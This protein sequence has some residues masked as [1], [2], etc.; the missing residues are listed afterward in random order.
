MNVFFFGCLVGFL[1]PFKK[2]NMLVKWQLDS[3]WGIGLIMEKNALGVVWVLTRWKHFSALLC[4]LS[5]EDG[6]GSPARFWKLRRNFLISKILQG[7]LCAP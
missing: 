5:W 4:S 7:R 2:G 1:L 6:S 3:N